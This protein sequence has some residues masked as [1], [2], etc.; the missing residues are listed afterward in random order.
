MIVCLSCVLFTAILTTISSV[1]LLRF[2]V[3][4]TYTTLLHY[5]IPYHLFPCSDRTGSTDGLNILV[6][7]MGRHKEHHNKEKDDME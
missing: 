3:P 1:V 2:P 7:S 5:F 6:E 4:L